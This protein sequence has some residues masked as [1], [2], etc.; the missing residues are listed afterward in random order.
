MSWWVHNVFESQGL[1]YLL[2]WIFWILLSITLHELAHG[3]AA[4]WEGDHTPIETGHM[5]GNPLVHM[6]GFSLIVFALIGFAWGLMP[7]RPWNFRHRRWGDAIVSIAGPV[8]NLLIAFVTLTSLGVWIGLDPNMFQH[9][10]PAWKEHVRNFLELGGFLNLV[11]FALNLLPVPPLDGSRILSA[12]SATIRGWYQ[13]PNAGM[14]GMVLFFL[15][16]TTN[17]FDS[18]VMVLGMAAVKYTASIAS[19][20]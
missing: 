7:V 17:I 9:G 4:I 19:L 13:H 16:L 20:F 18:V 6:G 15:I 12:F 5:T 3:W 1:P 14:A 11:L 8:M 10:E 2:S